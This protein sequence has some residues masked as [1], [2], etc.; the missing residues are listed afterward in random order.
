MFAMHRLAMGLFV[1]LAACAQSLGDDAF[2]VCHPLCRCAFVLPGERRS[3]TDSCMTQFARNP[4]SETCIACVVE[5]AD[6]CPTLIDDCVPVCTQAVPLD[7]CP[8]GDAPRIE[9]L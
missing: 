3:C 2:S 1:V 4:L 9:D 6:R 5:H 8:E 7:C